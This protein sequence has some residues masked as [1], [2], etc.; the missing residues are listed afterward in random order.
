[1]FKAYI[2]DQPLTACRRRLMFFQVGYPVAQC[3][4]VFFHAVDLTARGA[5]SLATIGS[6]PKSTLTAARLNRENN[7]AMPPIISITIQEI[8]FFTVVSSLIGAADRSAP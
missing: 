3:R 5:G 6:G 2:N 4:K 7:N 1:V 8:N